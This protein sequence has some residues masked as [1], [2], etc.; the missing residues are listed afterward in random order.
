MEVGKSARL[1]LGWKVGIGLAVL[2]ALEYALAVYLPG[3][4]L[5]Y[6]AVVALIKAWLIVQYFMHIAHLWHGGEQ[7]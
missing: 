3:N 4:P 2:T 5:P 1:R 7:Q 6:L